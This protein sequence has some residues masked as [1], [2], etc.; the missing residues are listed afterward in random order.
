MGQPSSMPKK[1][2]P[3]EGPDDSPGKE[4][5]H[6]YQRRI[7]K[8][9]AETKHLKA[10]GA[11]LLWHRTLD[12]DLTQSLRVRF[13]PQTRDAANTLLEYPGG[14]ASFSARVH[15][16]R[17]MGIFGPITYAD[18]KIINSI[19]N[20]IAHPRKGTLDE[21]VAEEFE[22]EKFLKACG[23]LKFL[24]HRYYGSESEKLLVGLKRYTQTVISI[25]FAL[26][27][28]QE[29]PMRANPDMSYREFDLGDILWLP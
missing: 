20:D 18:L 27:A 12:Y 16:G 1:T 11:I 4:V 22:S 14:L 8:F 24:D 6:E 9:N 21:L 23:K 3:I 26:Y 10:Y 15:L 7:T 29:Y 19:R 25:A 2:R 17:C 13:A 28:C 5:R